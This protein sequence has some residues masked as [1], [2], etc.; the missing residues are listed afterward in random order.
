[1]AKKSRYLV[2]GG[3]GFI[4]SHLVEELLR[5]GNEVIVL[6]NLCI[7]KK[8]RIPKTAKFYNV[9]IRNYNSIKDLFKGVD[10]VFHLAAQA[11]IQ[12]SIQDPRETMDVNVNGTTN[13][14]L[15]A[16]DNKV[17]K[18]IYSA[19]SS[20]YGNQKELPLHEEMTPE[21]KTP[22]AISKY[23]GEQL[24]KMFNELYGLP[25]ISLR[26]FN[27]HGPR[28]PE[29]KFAS[30]YATVIGIFLKQ[31]KENLKLTIIGDGEQKRDFTY[32]SDVVNANILAAKSIAGKGEV[33]NIGTG[34]TFSI[35]E[36]ASIVLGTDR[37]NELVD[38][39]PKRPAE[40]KATLADISKAKQLLG[41]EP[42]IHLEEGI[43]LT[44]NSD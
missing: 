26:Y 17:K 8:E 12:P 5:Q 33:I 9:D 30:S 43:K 36:V 32:V 38:Y 6:D 7:G 35:N 11:R 40:V 27:V 13:V 18:V 4:G 23:M 25:T 22:Y 15:A 24:C 1:M 16:R 3:A 42:K 28:Q 2:T 34:K 39:L 14:L 37:I 29:D 20:A 10:Y 19:S 44:M 31:K 41:W 21:P